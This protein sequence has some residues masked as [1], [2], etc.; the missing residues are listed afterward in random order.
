MG[1][2]EKPVVFSCAG[3]SLV[4]IIHQAKRPLGIGVLLVVGGPQY[5]VGSHRQFVTL[6]RYLAEQGVTVFR[7]DYRGMGDSTGSMQDFE[8]ASSDIKC[9]VN[10]FLEHESDIQTLVLWGLCDAASAI[11]FYASGDIRINGLVL[12]NP[13]VRTEHGESRV[14]LKD[15][16]LK[17]F[18]SKAFWQKVFSG[19]VDLVDSCKSL[20]HKT[21]NVFK[22]QPQIQAIDTASLPD[23]V[24]N[25]M[26][27]FKKPILFVFSGK[28]LTAKEFL[29]LIDAQNIG[30][31]LMERGNVTRVDLGES[32]HTFSH[33]VWKEQVNE[34]TLKWV[35]EL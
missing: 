4:G 1:V 6:A 25:S 31:Q 7:F 32:D 3:E 28:D 34:A 22:T 9:A 21:A 23:R 11:C 27:Q 19:D 30:T 12:L 5:R 8:Q 26:N 14:F 29:Q 20:G 2:S 16:Y 13:W 15:Y 17:R 33:K 35:K 10:S 24:L 18:C